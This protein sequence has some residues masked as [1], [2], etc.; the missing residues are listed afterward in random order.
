MNL[1]DGDQFTVT[2]D[3]KLLH[4]RRTLPGGKSE[5]VMWWRLV[6][7]E[8]SVSMEAGLEG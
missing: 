5:R 1:G 3:R 2:P 6:S 7:D 8:D 4:I